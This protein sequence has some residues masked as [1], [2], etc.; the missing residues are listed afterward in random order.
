MSRSCVRTGRAIRVTSAGERVGSPR[1]LSACVFA[2]VCVVTSALGHALMSGDLLP[3]WALGVALAGTASAGWWLTCRERGPVAVVGVTTVAQGLLHLW[4][5]VAHQIVRVPGAGFAS[6][7]DR[8]TMLP[9][10]GTAVHVGHSGSGTTL[11]HSGA[12]GASHVVSASSVAV[13][14]GALAMLLAHLLAAVVCGVWLWRG[15]AAAYRLGRALAIALFA[16]LQRVHRLLGRQV[17]DRRPHA[18]RTAPDTAPT[19][20]NASTV[21]R[22]AVV[23]RGPPR[24]SPAVLRATVGPQ[25]AMVS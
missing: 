21:L 25:S 3:W 19:A 22:H 11:A 20:P 1:A 13:H 8:A 4:F 17:L 7:T 6:R 12:E 5:D 24:D 18:A 9:H 2:A 15:E 10:S 23:R 14:Q 16:P